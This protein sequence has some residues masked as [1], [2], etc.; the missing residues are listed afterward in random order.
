MIVQRL[1]KRAAPV[2]A[3][4]IALGIFLGR[5]SGV[6]GNLHRRGAAGEYNIALLMIL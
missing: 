4:F 2:A 5:A 1:F 6:L 3:P